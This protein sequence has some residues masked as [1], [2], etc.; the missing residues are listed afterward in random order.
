[1][2]GS[3]SNKLVLCY[4]INQQLGWQFT[5]GLAIY[6]VAEKD[7]LDIWVNGQ[8]VQTTVCLFK[9]FI[10]PYAIVPS[11]T[12]LVGKACIG[13]QPVKMSAQTQTIPKIL[14]QLM[15]GSNFEYNP[16]NQ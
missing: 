2:S 9:N 15:R 5:T 16:D 10:V 7:T 11:V 4:L 1:M 8:R 12:L 3:C 13:I 14:P 6:V